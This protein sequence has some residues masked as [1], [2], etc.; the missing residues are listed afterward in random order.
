MVAQVQG[1]IS[2]RAKAE[3][4]EYLSILDGA[5]VTLEERFKNYELLGDKNNML[6]IFNELIN[7]NLIEIGDYRLCEKNRYDSVDGKRKKVREKYKG[8]DGAVAS[9][10]ALYDPKK[11]G[12]IGSW[13]LHPLA[14]ETGCLVKTFTHWGIRSEKGH[15]A[16]VVFSENLW[17]VGIQLIDNVPKAA[18]AAT[19]IATAMRNNGKEVSSLEESDLV[20][21]LRT[22]CYRV[23]SI[24]CNKWASYDQN[25]GWVVVQHSKVA[26]TVQAKVY[27]DWKV[28]VRKFVDIRQFMAEVKQAIN[29][30]LNIENIVYDKS[31]AQTAVEM[32][33]AVIKK[34]N[35]FADKHNGDGKI[36]L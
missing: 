20:N 17:P 15:E 33:K 11:G 30:G 25:I 23:Y 34:N 14:K 8:F 3:I 7:M 6:E 24:T 31:M 2:K 16:P 35:D 13:V 4:D 28:V 36:I 18:K 5:R 29:S 27:I 9:N 10:R 19:S 32:Q 22:G 21:Y 12:Y 1:K 26:K